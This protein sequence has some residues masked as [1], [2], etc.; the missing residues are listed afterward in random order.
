MGNDLSSAESVRNMPSVLVHL[1]VLGSI[2]LNRS[3][4][5]VAQS[6]N[7]ILLRSS[8]PF[9]PGALV[10]TSI[11]DRMILGEVVH[12]RNLEDGVELSVET[13]HSFPQSWQ[14]HP[15]WRGDAPES[16]LDSLLA[17]NERLMAF[18]P[19]SEVPVERRPTRRPLG[20]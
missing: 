6:G 10:E 3:A 2:S 16:V 4:V 11:S 12:S 7:R 8:G 15:A 1:K 17:L 13:H 18:A 9:P 20:K 19:P 14:P 5:I